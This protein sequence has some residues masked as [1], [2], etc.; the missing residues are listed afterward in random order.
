MN[1]LYKKAYPIFAFCLSISTPI[2]IGVRLLLVKDRQV[3]LV[4]HVYQDGWYLVGGGAKRNE[5]LEQTARREAY[6]EAGAKLGEI[7][8]FGI[9]SHFPEGRTDHIIVFV[10]EEF[11]FS[12]QS[13]AEID[14]LRLFPLDQ[15][16]ADILPGNSR[17]IAE[18]RNNPNQIS[19]GNW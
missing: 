18:Y 9:F 13:D 8:L 6:E 1:W 11:T 2:T 12:G 5:T 14:E 7:R 10:C 17:R 16:P 4:K 3:L 15:L 19:Y